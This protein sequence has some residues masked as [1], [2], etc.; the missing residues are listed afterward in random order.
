MPGYFSPSLRRRLAPLLLLVGVLLFGKVAH[1]ELPRSQEVRF[2]LSPEQR[3]ASAVRVTYA[4]R[5]EVLAGLERRF[6]GGAPAEFTH[7]PSL[8][9]GRYDVA[10]AVTAPDGR[11]T[12]FSRALHVPAEGATR[13]VLRDGGQ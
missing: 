12:H 8:K 1:E 3:T 7:A 6:P 9:P 11:V 13:I 4:E 5:G 2:V 10:I